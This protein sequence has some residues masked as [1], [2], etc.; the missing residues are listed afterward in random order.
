MGSRANPSLRIASPRYIKIQ[1]PKGLS[2]TFKTIRDIDVKGKIVLLR[3][4][5]NVPAKNGVVSD[6]TRI[7]R[8]KPTVD[9]LVSQG[10]KILV[11]SHFGRP[12]AAPD[13]DFSMAFL[14]PVLKAR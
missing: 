14:A 2:M 6:A 4:D 11:L 1:Q 8:L 5:L 12:K 3:A 10:A 9:Y 13:P 7:D